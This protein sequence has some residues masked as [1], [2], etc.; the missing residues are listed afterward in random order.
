MS[1][2]RVVGNFTLFFAVFFI[3]VE[4]LRSATPVEKPNGGDSFVRFL[5]NFVGFPRLVE[6]LSHSRFF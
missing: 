3:F 5:T 1:N 6:N 4:K 2:H